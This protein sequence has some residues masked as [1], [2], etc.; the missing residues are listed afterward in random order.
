[1]HVFSNSGA[2]EKNI[3]YSKGKKDFTGTIFFT[4]L[5]GN[6]VNGWQYEKG[7]ITGK[8]NKEMTLSNPA[9]KSLPPGE[10]GTCQTTEVL[11]FERDCV[12]YYNGNYQCGQWTYLYSTY[13]TTCIPSGSGGGGSYGDDGGAGT[14]TPNCDNYIADF[15]TYAASGIEMSEKRPITTNSQT[16][17]MRD[18]N[19]PWAVYMFPGSSLPFVGTLPPIIFISHETGITV[20]NN[21]N[22]WVW[23]SLTHKTFSKEGTSVV[24]IP[25]ISLNNANA[26]ISGPIATMDLSFNI[27]VAVICKGVAIEK[28]SNHNRFNRW[29]ASE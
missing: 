26:N 3:T 7:K 29:Y 18:K 6:F 13:Y 22:E 14:G 17:V 24:I 11:W 15:N 2:E 10:G 21:A 23:E 12:E 20:K 25:S 8:S 16:S 9:G 4:D 27:G 1:M 28:G 19:Y 5:D